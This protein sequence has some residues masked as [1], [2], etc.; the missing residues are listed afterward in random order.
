MN[1]GLVAREK[2]G[3]CTHHKE[4][5]V[6]NLHGDKLLGLWSGVRKCLKGEHFT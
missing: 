5:Q 1:G 4:M 2:P 6:V 3:F